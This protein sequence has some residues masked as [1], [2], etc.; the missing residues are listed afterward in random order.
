MS[1]NRTR[2]SERPAPMFESLEP[3]LLLSSQTFVDW[4]LDRVTV[5]L[6]GPGS[7]AI[8]EGVQ[9]TDLAR[10]KVIALTDV[11][12]CQTT[13]SIKVTRNGGDGF[14]DVGRITGGAN[15]GLHALDAPNANI[16]GTGTV[17]DPDGDGSGFGIDLE[18]YVQTFTVHN[19]TNGVDVRAKQGAYYFPTC[20][21]TNFTAWDIGPDTT[22]TLGSWVDALKAHSWDVGGTL[23]AKG[24]NK[25]D[26]AGNFGADITLFRGPTAGPI[27]VV[28]TVVSTPANPTDWVFPTDV[29]AITVGA[30]TANWN[31][32]AAAAA[33]PSLTCK[34]DLSF[35][36]I[37][38]VSL[39][40]LSVTGNMPTG[41]L[42]LTQVV[43]P[44]KK[45]LAL[46]TVTVGKTVGNTDVA[47]PAPNWAISGDAGAITIGASNNDWVFSAAGAVS[48]LTCKGNLAF[49]TLGALSIGSLSV[50]G[51]LTSGS[52]TL[53][54]A[55][56]PKKP[57]LGSAGI[58][59]Q[60]AS[61]GAVGWTI[62]G[63][64]GATTIKSSTTGWTVDV[65]GDVKSLTVKA[66]L[67]LAGWQSLTLGKL[68]VTGDMNA[69]VMRL[70]SAGT[71]CTSASI[72]GWL[73]SSTIRAAGSI[74]SFKAKGMSTGNVFAGVDPLG[75]TGA[76]TNFSA[77]IGNI[78]VT[79][80]STPSPS[81]WM[82]GSEFRM[83]ILGTAFIQGPES[84][85]G[86]VFAVRT[87]ASGSLKAR[88][89][90]GFT[91]TFTTLAAW[92][93]AD[94]LNVVIL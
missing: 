31:I 26:S 78:N 53:T 63:N 32:T 70:Q 17:T 3:R 81:H 46:G 90:D 22:V 25:L 59:G 6:D 43:D 34:G 48:S 85:T 80:Q 37:R 83:G 10:L 52:M 51:D 42:T 29:G 12:G 16:I 33:M 44:V 35:G 86:N 14:V 47:I 65:E 71:S 45:P 5:T 4:D 8:Q 60:V 92:E 30:G 75:T 13:L 79:G 28:G 94:R 36:T 68:S 73:S 24:L 56:D 76:V 74:G 40:K 67:A 89:Y 87:I 20:I 57:A 11:E 72:G 2:R 50:T 66:N 69:G 19:I 7:M 84:G 39:A 9:D 58:G 64:V 54:Q 88:R 23:D 38:A 21:K 93:A 27:N 49:A 1:N 82:T 62:A 18:G 55:V 91:Y 61:A 15:C 41:A 77:K